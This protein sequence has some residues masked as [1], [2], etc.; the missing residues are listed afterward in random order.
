M[1]LSTVGALTDL[2]AALVVSTRQWRAETSTSASAASIED[3]IRAVEEQIDRVRD[4]ARLS[5]SD[6]SKLDSVG[7]ELW[8]A[9]RIPVMEACPD[10]AERKTMNGGGTPKLPSYAHRRETI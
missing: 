10:D 2:A 4:S 6:R 1:A 5:T 9:F 7:T 8:N 3:D